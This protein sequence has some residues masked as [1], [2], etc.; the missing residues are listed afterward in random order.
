[1]KKENLSSL[2]TVEAIAASIIDDVDLMALPP[3]YLQRQGNQFY[4]LLTIHA[5][6]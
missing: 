1:L 3:L 2:L 4:C 6:L 5:T